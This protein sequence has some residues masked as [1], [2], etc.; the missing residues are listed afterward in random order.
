LTNLIPRAT[1]IVAGLMPGVAVVIVA[2]NSG[3]GG[4][5]RCARRAIHSNL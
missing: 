2:A 1:I 4:R 3:A 5:L